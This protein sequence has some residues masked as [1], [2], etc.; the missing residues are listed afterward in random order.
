ML[1]T[2]ERGA[3]RSVRDYRGCVISRQSAKVT[4]LAIFHNNIGEYLYGL[5]PKRSLEQKK[6]PA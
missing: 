5:G 3:H 4:E 1:L 2:A 6:R